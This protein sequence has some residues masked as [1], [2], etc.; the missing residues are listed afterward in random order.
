MA[1]STK[2]VPTPSAKSPRTPQPAATETP[3]SMTVKLDR[4]TYRR[5]AAFA[6]MGEK[7]RTHQEVMKTALI[8]YLERRKA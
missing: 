1:P 4:E 6:T 2:K 7:L 8:E 3:V 5:L